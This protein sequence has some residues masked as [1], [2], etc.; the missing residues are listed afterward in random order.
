[1]LPQLCDRL[2]LHLLIISEDLSPHLRFLQVINHTADP[3]LDDGQGYIDK[4]K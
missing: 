1:M 2:R 4:K 3:L